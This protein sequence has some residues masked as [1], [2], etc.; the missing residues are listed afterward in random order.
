MHR[1]LFQRKTRCYSVVY[2]IRTAGN[3]DS[4]KKTAGALQLLEIRQMMN[5]DSESWTF[6]PE[7]YRTIVTDF[8]FIYSV[9]FFS[10]L[11]GVSCNALF[12]SS[13]KPDFLDPINSSY[14]KS[15]TLSCYY[16]VSFTSTLN[17]MLFVLLRP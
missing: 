8:C 9:S 6:L 7:T 15:N 10:R 3:N 12:R 14:F 1:V 11:S 13:S 17:R 4:S 16:F 2:H 5:V